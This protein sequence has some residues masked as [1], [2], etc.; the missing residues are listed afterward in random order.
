MAGVEYPVVTL[1]FGG[2]ILDLPIWSEWLWAL[3]E[4]LVHFSV[5][6]FRQNWAEKWCA[7]RPLWG[8]QKH[9]ELLFQKYVPG[10][11]MWGMVKSSASGTAAWQSP[12]WVAQS[13]NIEAFDVSLCRCTG[14]EVLTPILRTTAG[15]MN[16]LYTISTF[17]SNRMNSYYSHTLRENISSLP[18]V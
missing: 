6:S 2:F 7:S 17:G 13:K 15:G 11:K 10:Q 3:G 16:G 5:P 14:T 18:E 8:E 1:Y 12:A 4:Y 9:C